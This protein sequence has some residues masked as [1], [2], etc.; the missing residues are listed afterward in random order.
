MSSRTGFLSLSLSY[1]DPNGL[2]DVVYLAGGMGNSLTQGQAEG[3][4]VCWLS[5]RVT[6]KETLFL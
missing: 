6:E 3:R 4:A 2:I 5:R 1:P